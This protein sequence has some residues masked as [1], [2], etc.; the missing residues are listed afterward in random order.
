MIS[1]AGQ[2]PG[3]LAEGGRPGAGQAQGQLG[4]GVG[5]RDGVHRHVVEVHDGGGALGRGPH[6]GGGHL[7]GGHPL[8]QVGG[9]DDEVG[10][11]AGGPGHRAGGL[12]DEEG[13]AVGRGP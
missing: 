8:Q 11:E 1:I 5:H 13:E 4:H 10:V 9:P 12:L 7:V 2:V 3:Q 6:E